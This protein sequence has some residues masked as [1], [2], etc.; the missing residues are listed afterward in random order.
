MSF[1]NFF[2]RYVYSIIFN[3][4]IGEKVF[5]SEEFICH[6]SPDF[7]L[8]TSNNHISL[9][10]QKE[11]ISKQ[12][13]EIDEIKKI[14]QIKRINPNYQSIPFNSILTHHRARE[15]IDKH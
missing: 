3:G 9:S 12:I 8:N 7:L 10:H 14:S 5:T 2:C 15:Q 6:L 1:R 13:D 4:V 11:L